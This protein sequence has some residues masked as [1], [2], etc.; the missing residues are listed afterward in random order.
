MKLSVELKNEEGKTTKYSADFAKTEEEVRKV[1]KGMEQW[2]KETF[3][4]ETNTKTP[5]I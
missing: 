1:C 4:K 5:I 2:L 3:T